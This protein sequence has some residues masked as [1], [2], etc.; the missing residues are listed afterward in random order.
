MPRTKVARQACGGLSFPARARRTPGGQSCPE[1]TGTPGST[2]RSRRNP[3]PGESTGQRMS[4]VLWGRGA[5][6]RAAIEAE[7]KEAMS[8]GARIAETQ[9]LNMRSGVNSTK[10]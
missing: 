1:G 8:A 4:L 2:R 3:A 9:E 6:E 10:A 5:A 7:T